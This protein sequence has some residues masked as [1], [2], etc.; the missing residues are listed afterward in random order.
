MN[1]N[2]SKGEIRMAKR[3]MIKMLCITNHQGD[4]DQ[5]NYEIPPHTTENG[6]HPKE[7]KQPV[8]ERMWRERDSSTLLVGMSTGPA[9]LENNMDASQ[10][11][12]N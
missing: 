11:I 8:L 4:A 6:T 2:F 5:N 1:R 12:R 10:K 9:L 3:H 7:Q